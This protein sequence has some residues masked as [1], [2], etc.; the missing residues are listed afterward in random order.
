MLWGHLLQKTGI[1]VLSGSSDTGKS[2]LLR[3]LSLG[4]ITKQD[5]FLGLALKPTHYRVIYISTEDDEQS[6][7]PRIKKERKED[8]EAVDFE[9]L[10]F[11]IDGEDPFE[12]AKNEF[13]KKPA[14][15]II[16]DTWGD[17]ADGDLNSANNVRTPL[18]AIRS[19]AIRNNCLFI[20]NHHNRKSASEFDTSKRNLLGSQSL[21]AKARV[22]L[23]LT[24]DNDDPTLRK[25]NVSKGNYIPNELKQRSLVLRVNKD[26]VFEYL[27]EVENPISNR[28]ETDKRRDENLEA[29]NL[30][31]QQG[32]KPTEIIA[33]IPSLVKNP[34][35]KSA[36]RKLI[37]DSANKSTSTHQ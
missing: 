34:F 26:F 15:C 25:L 17:Y 36:L 16:I 20:I 19:F 2:T 13:E 5:K 18:K 23:M 31:L 27:T 30:L 21:E 37:K 4:I 10:T 14:D 32:K 29:V 24:M 35:K 1:A 9:N 22:V 11:I 6:L 33:E 7:S 12:A 8:S 28:K 3:Q